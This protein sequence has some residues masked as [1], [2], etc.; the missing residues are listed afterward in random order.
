MILKLKLYIIFGLLLFKIIYFFFFS[1][2]ILLSE[3]G[4][5]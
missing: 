5:H 4:K 3:L 1:G 2:C